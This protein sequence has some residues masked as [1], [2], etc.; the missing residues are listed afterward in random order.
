MA[1]LT[2]SNYSPAA[3]DIK[4]FCA[5]PKVVNHVGLMTPT[6]KEYILYRYMA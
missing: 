3:V 4:I 6:E 2:Y 5:R 1:Q